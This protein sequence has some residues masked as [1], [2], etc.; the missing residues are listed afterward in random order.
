MDSVNVSLTSQVNSKFYITQDQVVASL[1]NT[2]SACAGHAMIVTEGLD[3]KDNLTV[4]QYEVRSKLIVSRTIGEKV[5]QTMGNCQGYIA[6][7]RVIETNRYTYP[8]EFAEL[9]SK[10]W[11]AKPEEIQKMVQSIVEDKTAIEK[12]IAEGKELPLLY[13]TAGSQRWWWFGGNGGDSCLTWAE[14]KLREAGIEP[15]TSWFDYIKA[16]PEFHVDSK[17]LSRWIPSG[18]ISSK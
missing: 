13:Q 7:I 4:G 1:F 10:S 14:N 17:T 18:W 16:V 15:K 8:K 5:Q 11:Y 9:S 6:E 3:E 12:A 2:G